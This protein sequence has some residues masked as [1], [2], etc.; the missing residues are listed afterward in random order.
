MM[1]PYSVLK[2]LAITGVTALSA[3]V[4]QNFY[5]TIKDVYVQGVLTGAPSGLVF[6]AADSLTGLGYERD[7]IIENVI[8]NV[9]ATGAWV[10]DGVFRLLAGASAKCSATVTDCYGISDIATGLY[11]ETAWGAAVGT[12][13]VYESGEKL[14]AGIGELPESFCE[15]WKIENGKL[16]FG[17]NAVIG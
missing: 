10:N 7:E 1:S 14:I 17:G 11:S 9:T 5:G 3:V 15:F 12:D 4:A 13:R 2:N 6:V 16:Y 8:V